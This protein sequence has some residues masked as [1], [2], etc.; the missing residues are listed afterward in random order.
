[1]NVRLMEASTIIIAIVLEVNVNARLTKLDNRVGG[2]FN[3]YSKYSYDILV[4]N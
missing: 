2:L 3:L 1:M 4:F